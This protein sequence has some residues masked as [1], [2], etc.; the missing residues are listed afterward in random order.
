MGL[1]SDSNEMLEAARTLKTHSPRL[2]GP[3]YY[4]LGH[5]FEVGVKSFLLAKGFSEEQ[6][7]KKIGHDLCK[8]LAAATKVGIIDFYAFS[9]QELDS[10]TQLNPYYRSKELEYRVTGF[11]SYPDDEAFSN[12]IEGML[13]SI[14][15]ICRESIN[16]K[17]NKPRLLRP[18]HRSAAGLGLN[19]ASRDFAVA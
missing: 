13:T 18:K 19:H 2:I 1:W 10:I 11:K 12:M 16:E 7:R 6:L 14:R 3:K 8:A 17:P 15:S 5:S 9:E 4:L